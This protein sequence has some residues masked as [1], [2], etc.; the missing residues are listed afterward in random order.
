MMAMMMMMM[1][2]MMMRTEYLCMCPTRQTES[3]SVYL[4]I[5]LLCVFYVCLV[6]HLHQ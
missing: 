4:G 6:Y 3:L 2:M 5:Q 1:M